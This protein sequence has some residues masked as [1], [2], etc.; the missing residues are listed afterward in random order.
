VSKAVFDRINC[1]I[2]KDFLG[3]YKT[4]VMGMLVKEWDF[5]AEIAVLTEEAREEGWEKGR[6]EEK[7]NNA[8][9]MKAAGIDVDTVAKITGL[10]PN[11][12]AR[13]S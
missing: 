11:H 8:R 7:E 1:G 12:I 9:A 3:T 2:L 4:E 13:L 6:E 10:T 5:E